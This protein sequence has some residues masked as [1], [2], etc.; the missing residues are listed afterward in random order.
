MP[1][2][3]DPAGI[4]DAALAAALRPAFEGASF[5]LHEDGTAFATR[6]KDTYTLATEWVANHELPEFLTR[7][8]L[9]FFPA[10]V[11]VDEVEALVVSLW[12]EGGWLSPGILGL[13]SRASMT[14]PWLIPAGMRRVLRLP[15]F[16]AVA[17][18]VQVRR[19]REV[20]PVSAPQDPLAPLFS[21]VLP[22]GEEYETLLALLEVGRRLRGGMR[23]DMGLVFV[24]D[25]DASVNLTLY[26]AEPFVGSRVLRVLQR[27]GVGSVRDLAGGA[28]QISPSAAL[29][30]LGSRTRSRVEL[31]ALQAAGVSD[32]DLVR[33]DGGAA[34]FDRSVFEFAPKT[35]GGSGGSFSGEVNSPEG[36]FSFQVPLRSGGAVV[37]AGVGAVPA[38]AVLRWEDWATE[39]VF[40]C[41][42]R[43]DPSQ[44]A[45]AYRNNLGRALRLE[46]M[47]ATQVIEDVAA[48]LLAEFGGEAVDDAGFLVGF[49]AE[50]N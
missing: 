50:Q 31:R 9:L 18:S 37:V 22:V 45:V 35:V 14:G 8:H 46:R 30:H 19:E 10:D 2:A 40:G 24:P 12:P 44:P 34:D 5:R 1:K 28:P 7:E 43:W 49:Q 25:P 38:P 3:F 23:S 6:A 39:V 26:A 36:V 15:A 17:F 21:H 29:S 33:I 4:R 16:A 47:A 41:E 32:S 27:A 42:L 48:L 13:H 20:P 11:S